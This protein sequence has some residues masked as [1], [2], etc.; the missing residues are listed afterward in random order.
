M[1]AGARVDC[2]GAACTPY[3]SGEPCDGEHAGCYLK[4][5]VTGV[6]D[7]EFT[8][9]R[10]PDE[11]TDPAPISCA[12]TVDGTAVTVTA[13]VG[14]FDATRDCY[15]YEVPAGGATLGSGCV[16]VLAG[17][18]GIWFDSD[19]AVHSCRAF[20][21]L[22]HVSGTSDQFTFEAYYLGNK[23]HSPPVCVGCGSA[24]L[25]IPGSGWLATYAGFNPDGSVMV[26]SVPSGTIGG[27]Q[28]MAV[29]LYDMCYSRDSG[30]DCASSSPLGGSPRSFT[31]TA[32]GDP[33]A[34]ITANV[35]TRVMFARDDVFPLPV[36]VPPP[37]PN[38]P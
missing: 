3:F 21:A 30:G 32:G 35:V 28:V 22:S 34:N 1:P 37:D 10:D 7:G 12:T 23:L 2:K 25:T 33:E 27:Y 17:H 11:T 8:W 18:G 26:Y 38:D 20:A 6:K 15:P 24:P 36:A 5:R 29:S 31:I 14:A 16:G 9:F 13:S 4:Y 19:P